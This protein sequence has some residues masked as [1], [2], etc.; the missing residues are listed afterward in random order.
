MT[1]TAKVYGN[2][3]KNA[4]NGII[5][6]SRLRVILLANTYT[7]DQDYHEFLDDVNP[8]EV[9]GTNYVS[10]GQLLDNPTCTYDVS[11]HSVII[12]CDDEIFSDVTITARYAIFYI[13]IVGE[14]DNGK[15]LVGYWDLGED[16]TATSG[17]FRLTM[18]STGVIK[19]PVNNT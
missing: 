9:E 11:I 7:P 3:L 19:I 14:N 13:D 6:L 16:E 4:V 5:D 12:D 10:G 1:L 2:F 8:H 18:D 15:P 17:S